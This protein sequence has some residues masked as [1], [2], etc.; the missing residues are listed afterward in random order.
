MTD[1]ILRVTDPCQPLPVDLSRPLYVY[2][3]K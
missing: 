1:H 3:F 2:L